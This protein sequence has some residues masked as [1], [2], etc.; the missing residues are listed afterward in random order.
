M[1][2][3]NRVAFVLLLVVAFLL[4]ACSVGIAGAEQKNP[5][6]IW[7]QNENAYVH[8]WVVVDDNTG[9]NYIALTTQRGSNDSMTCCI[10]PRLNPD[11]SLYVS[12]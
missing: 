10:T 2:H 12:P 1:K 4:G 7:Y 8:T 5:I 11:G 3:L 6:K 9:V